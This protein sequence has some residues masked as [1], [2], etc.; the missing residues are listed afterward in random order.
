MIRKADD[1]FISLFFVIS[2][3]TINLGRDY[4]DENGMISAIY[5][6]LNDSIL[7]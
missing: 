7:K 2:S 1:P 3:L 4:G 5:V 6:T